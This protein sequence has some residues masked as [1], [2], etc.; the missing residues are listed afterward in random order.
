MRMKET[1]KIKYW[2]AEKGFGFISYGKQ[3]EVFAH[4]SFLEDKTIGKLLTGQT[5]EFSVIQGNEKGPMASEIVIIN[6]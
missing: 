3:Q 4:I 5:V 6:D 2:N 1:G